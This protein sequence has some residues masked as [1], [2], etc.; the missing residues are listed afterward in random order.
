[1]SVSNFLTKTNVAMIWDVISDEDM[2]KAFVYHQIKRF[3]FDKVA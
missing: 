1:M 2:F 3:L